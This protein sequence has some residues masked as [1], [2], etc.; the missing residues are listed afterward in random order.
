V[1]TMSANKEN[2]PKDGAE[3]SNS[4]K[5]IQ[6]DAFRPVADASDIEALWTDTGLADPLTSVTRYSVPVGRP[7]DFYRTHPDR[8]Y[9]RRTEV[10]VH[11]PAGVIEEVTYIVAPAMH[12]RIT[13]ARPC[14]L[15]AVVDR[16]GIP[17]LWPLKLP[18]EG[19]RDNRAWETARIAARKG[20][21]WW[22]KV[23]WERGAFVTRDAMAGYAPDPDFSKLPPFNEL[24]QT[25]FGQHGVISDTSHPIYRELFGAPREIPE[26]AAD[27]L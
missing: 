9:R 10:Y 26:G 19:E 11:K 15:A 8:D 13:E 22:V 14:I 18:R 6:P 7:K 5:I 24:V 25:A 17:G 16:N 12:G 27:D 23:L 3:P 21:D 20:I 4:E 2:Q 1:I